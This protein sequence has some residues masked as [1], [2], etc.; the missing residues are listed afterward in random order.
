VS[1]T[2]VA[3]VV[4]AGSGE[5][6]GA[7]VP[8]AFVPLGGEPMLVWSVRA[9]LAC[10]SIGSVAVA[11]PPGGEDL[12][13]AMLE[14]AGPHAVVAGGDS[15]QSSV[16]A[17]LA[18]VPR[19]ADVVVVHDAARPFATSSLFSAIVD[20][21]EDADGAVPVVGLADTVKHV[22]DGWVVA[23]PAREELAAAQTPQAF[24]ASALRDA[25][26]RASAE[27]VEFTDDA[28][29]LE[30][31]GYRVRAVEGE[32]GNFKVTTAADLDRANERVRTAAR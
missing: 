27:G 18:A 14:D 9:A 10:P 30:W 5:R 28:G 7:A 24:R 3:I 13:H 11:A 16:R 6:L 8:K 22:R 31:A 4:A 21:L 2:A 15:R 29:M 12:A 26:A 23:T 17:A 25:H 19:E 32:P 20:A 1:G